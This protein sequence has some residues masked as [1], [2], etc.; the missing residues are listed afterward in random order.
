MN[1]KLFFIIKARLNN[2]FKIHSEVCTNHGLSRPVVPLSG[3][4]NLVDR[5]LHQGRVS[6]IFLATWKICCTSRFR[7]LPCIGI[8]E[9]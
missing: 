6:G 1:F 8:L 3:K 7:I 4:S 9:R 2:I 5:S